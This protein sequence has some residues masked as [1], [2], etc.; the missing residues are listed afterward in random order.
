MVDYFPVVSAAWGVCDVAEHHHWVSHV[1]EDLSRLLCLKL[2]VKYIPEVDATIILLEIIL[3]T[4]EKKISRIVNIKMQ[5]QQCGN[6][7]SKIM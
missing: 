7:T 6:Y 4:L 1:A 2:T 5:C 3:V